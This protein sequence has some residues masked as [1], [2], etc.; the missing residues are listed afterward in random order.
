MK[1]IIFLLL[2]ITLFPAAFADAQVGVFGKQQLIEYTPLWT[3]ERFDDGRPKVSDDLL[4]R[5][6]QVSIEEA[7]AVCNRHKF[8]NQFEGNWVITRDNPVL[9]GRA[10]TA[11]FYPQRPDVNDKIN[12]NGKKDGRIGGQN[13]WIIDTI[14]HKDVIVVDLM[15]KVIDGTFLG[16]NLANS[17]WV[18][19]GG[20]GVVIDGGARDIEGVLQIPDFPI[21]NRG[22][23]PSYLKDVMLMGINT[24]VRIGRASV[25]PGDVVLGKKEGVIFIPAHLAEEVVQ[26]SEIVRL[27]DQFGHQRLREGKYTPGEIDRKWSEEIEKDF[28]LWLQEKG[29]ELT[30]YQKE[31]LLK[32]RTW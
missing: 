2:F 7:W 17:I 27:R 19:S 5:M 25:M 3:G 22:W 6:K 14:T 21:F 18:K 4:E 20:T 13:S 11:Y 29:D 8:F 24:P 28:G 32:G 23:D 1:K 15:G 31:K 10:V 26:T 12:E 16:D 9:V 30:P